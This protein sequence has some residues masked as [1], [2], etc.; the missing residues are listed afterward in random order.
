M[1]MRARRGPWP[2]AAAVLALFYLLL[3]AGQAAVA[4]AG[5]GPGGR[6]C[7][8]S[9]VAGSKKPS[10]KPGRLLKVKVR[11]ANS[12]GAGFSQGVLQLQLPLHVT[13]RKASPTV[14][15]GWG[16]A[17]T[18]PVYDPD[19]RTVTWSGLALGAKAHR[20]FTVRTR[21]DKCYAGPQLAFKATA[22]VLDPNANDPVPLCVQEA[23]AT[24][25]RACVRVC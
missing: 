15:A 8:L 18:S 11:W 10:V 22:Y 6:A 4:A 23:T 2:T 17:V 9:L 19:A 13:Y 7:S 24:V 12:A 20:I 1:G 16:G 25:V 5:D 21:V 14:K 3:L